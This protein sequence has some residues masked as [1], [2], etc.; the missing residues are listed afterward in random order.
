MF[1]CPASK[2]SATLPRRVTKPIK[3]PICSYLRKVISPYGFGW[4][5]ENGGV[6]RYANE[7][8]ISLDAAGRS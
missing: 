7:K 2:R 8:L 1:E 3:D 4:E 5:G 6:D